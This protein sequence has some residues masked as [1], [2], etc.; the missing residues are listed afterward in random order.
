MEAAPPKTELEVVK[1]GDLIRFSGYYKIS[2]SL[3]VI[4][5][6]S[7]SPRDGIVVG[8]DDK[9]IIVFSEDCFCFLNHDDAKA[10]QVNII[11]STE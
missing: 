5:E 3:G 11:N 2:S 9:Y 7:S 10:L 1:S 4:N 8:V 6:M